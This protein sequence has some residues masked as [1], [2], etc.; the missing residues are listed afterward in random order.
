MKTNSR[1]IMQIGAGIIVGVL[2]VFVL[3]KMYNTMYGRAEHYSD[4]DTCEGTTKTHTLYLFY[5]ETCPHCIDFQPI[6]NELL[7]DEGI[8]SKACLSKISEENDAML[9]KYQVESFPTLVLVNNTSKSSKVFEGK[10][11]FDTIKNF[12]SQYTS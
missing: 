12:V 5:M 11:T 3:R 9:Q 2:A 8:N 1:K 10:R 6:W 4:K 7:Q